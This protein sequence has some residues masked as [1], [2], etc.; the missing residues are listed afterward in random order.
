MPA[1]RTK[2]KPIKYKS[3]SEIIREEMQKTE[4]DYKELQKRVES[5]RSRMDKRTLEVS[6]STDN[7]KPVEV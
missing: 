1:Q 3:Q 2:P 7:R 6:D 4:K 5:I